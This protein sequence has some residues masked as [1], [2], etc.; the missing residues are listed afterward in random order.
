MK[1][2]LVCLTV[3]LLAGCSSGNSRENKRATPAQQASSRLEAP[4]QPLS[5]FSSFELKPLA[6]SEEI[7]NRPEKAAFVEQ[8]ESRLQARLSPLLDQWK[9]AASGPQ[10]GST[11]VIQPRLQYLHIVSGG[12]R[13]AVGAM[14]G[15]SFVDMDLE[16]TDAKTGTVIANQRIHQTGSS[17]RATWTMGASD[18]RLVGSIV[19]IAYQYLVDNYK[20]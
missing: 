7:S 8:L 19:E 13:F 1:K 15:S 20:K 18:R 3:V 14:A 10:G 5:T 2:A 12:A 9:A 11:L 6:L 16:L 17:R 4:A